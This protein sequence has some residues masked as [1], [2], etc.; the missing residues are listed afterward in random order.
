LFVSAVYGQ[1]ARS[2][3]SVNGSDANPCTVPQPCRTFVAA[4]AVT[5]A[6]G[7]ILALD[8]GGYGPFAINKSVRVRAIPGAYAGIAPSSGDAITINAAGAD[9]TLAGLTLNST[10]AAFGINVMNVGA[11]FIQNVEVAGFSGNGLNFASA[12][13]SQL[14]IEESTFRGNGSTCCPAVFIVP[15]SAGAKASLDHV[16]LEKNYTGMIVREYARVTMRDSSAVGNTTDGVFVGSV[17]AAVT[18]ELS[19]IN[20][21]LSNNAWG[22]ETNCCGSY[23][24]NPIVS[25]T[26]SLVSNNATAGLVANDLGTIRVSGATITRNNTGVAAAGSGATISFN[27]NALQGNGTDGAFTTTVALK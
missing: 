27:N 17:P 11:L 4:L 7:E 26:D 24:G 3:V 22:L 13:G 23:A 21:V 16:R 6:G 14:Y 8:S 1:N 12:S 10:G 9:V 25:I 5:N 2:A 20:S 19:I 15:S 18:A